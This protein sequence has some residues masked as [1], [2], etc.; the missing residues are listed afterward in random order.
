[1]ANVGASIRYNFGNLTNLA[2]RETRGQYWPWA[3]FLFILTMIGG[4]I[5]AMPMIIHLMNRM[6][7]MIADPRLAAGKPSPEL[8]QA[9]LQEVVAPM[10]ADM[11]TMVIVGAI[12]NLVFAILVG[13]ATARRLHDRDRSGWWGLLPLPF[14]AIGA[15]LAPRM[16]SSFMAVPG[17]LAMAP[18]TSLVMLTSLNNIAFYG[19]LGY[20]IYL[21]A[22]EGTT[23][24]N[25][26][27]E[28]PLGRTAA[29]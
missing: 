15:M 5:S 8:V 20:L 10:A 12:I 13:A 28:D 25:R 9:R 17:H 11:Q 6:M 22:T 2:G 19:A 16:M 21:L 24:A 27:G 29:G 23:G 1:M 14:M 26:F 7:G 3:I 18:N 4:M